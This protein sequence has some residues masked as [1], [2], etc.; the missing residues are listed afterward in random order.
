[1][2][3][4][5]VG[6]VLRRLGVGKGR[7]ERVLVAVS[8]GLD[9]VSLADILLGLRERLGFGVVL[10]HVNHG[11]RGEESEDDEAF[12]RTLASDW[13]VPVAVRRVDSAGLREDRSSRD[14]PTR[15]EAAREARYAALSEMAAGSGAAVVATA[16]T[17]D[18]QA[19]TVLLRLLR[20]TGPDG[21][22]GIPERSPDG[23]VWR[24]LL[25][26]SR[27]DLES[28][29]LE[30][31]LRWREDSSN[32]SDDYTRN[33]L[34]RH[35]LPGLTA[36]FNPRLLR[37]LASLAEAQRGDSEFIGAQ[38]DREVGCRFSNEDGWLRIDA[39]DWETLPP[40]L[41]L[42][43]ARAAMQRCG[44]ARHVSRVHLERMSRFLSRGRSGTQIEVPGGLKLV[45]DRAGF[46]LGRLTR[47]RPEAL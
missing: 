25:G 45:R 46:R 35:W 16:H 19:E 24:P 23:R 33:R 29:A 40:A 21:L 22:G 42:R 43:L 1:M 36:E 4:R 31:R 8:G 39:K 20:G 7:A 38:V 3:D 37:A 34:R 17:A 11:L 28:R 27:S 15:Q 10:A 26:I 9:S 32:A 13:Q 2:V 5:E 30:R 41:A 14:R 44:A 12:V 47:D 18:D 6:D